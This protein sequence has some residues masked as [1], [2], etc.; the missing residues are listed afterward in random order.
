MRNSSLAVKV[1][2]AVAA[3]SLGAFSITRNPQRDAPPAPGKSV[4]MAQ[5]GLAL[6]IQLGLKDAKS[7]DWD[8]EVR[9][10]PG[11]MALRDAQLQKTDRITGNSWR[12]SSR[13]VGQGP[14]QRTEPVVLYATSEAPPTANVDV[15]TKQGNFSFTLAEL[16]FGAPLTFL[17]G[18]AA[19]ERVPITQQLTSDPTEDDFAACAAPPD[20]SVWCAYVGY[21]RGS[22]LVAEDFNKGKFDSLITRNHGDQVR[23]MKFDGKQWTAPIDVTPAGL[24]V[25]RPT[26]AIDGNGAVWVIWSQ[27]TNGNWDL[28]ARSYDTK[29]NRWSND[30][31]VTSE[32]GADIHSVATTTRSGA[33][34][35]AWQSWGNGDFAIKAQ[36]LGGSGKS[37]PLTRDFPRGN[38]WQPSIA[39]DSKGKVYVAF[40]TYAKGNYDVYVW[41]LDE[42]A[43]NASG[44]IIPVATSS[45][46]EARPTMAV[47]GQDRVWIAYE[48]A[49]PNWG[50][51]YGTRWE[52]KTGAPFYLNRNVAVRCLEGGKLLQTKA[53][54]KSELIDTTYPPSERQR[55]SYP[56]ISTDGAGALWLLFR[57]HALKTGATERW[58]T[59][60]TYYSGDAW[61]GPILLPS[62]EN[63]LDNRPALVPMKGN[64]LLAV[65]SSDGRT[66]GT[67]TAVK[68]NLY[69]ALFSTE[70]SPKNP[71][72]VSVRPEGDGGTA[73]A[74][75]ADET[76][77]VNRIRA[78]RVSV[79][80]KTY[81]PLRG[82]FHR[83]TE[84]S[85]HRDQ[86]GPFEEIW[87]YGLDVARMDWIGPGDH[88]NGVGR[89][90]TWWLTQKQVDIYHHAPVFMPMFTYE[91]SVVFP[92]GHR[93]VMFARRGIRPLPR[94][95]TPQQQE[96]LYGSP[97]AG[98]PDIKNLYAYLKHF[99]GI[100][101][102]HTSATNMG[103]DWRDNDPA[104]EPVVEIY[105]GHRQNYEEPKAPKAAK[106]AE[107]SI[108]GF[109]PE[110]YVWNAFLKGYKLG[111][112]VSSDHV[113][114]HIS[115]GIVY[116][117]KPTR[118]AIVDAFKK[119][120]SYGA[121]DNIILDVRCG[122][123]M[124][125]DEFTSR[126]APK[127]DIQAIGTAPVA[128]IDIVRQIDR[129]T[130]AYVYAVEPKKPNVKI[131]WTDSKA[132]EGALNMY[133][134]RLMQEDGKMAWA[135]PMWIK[136]EP[137]SR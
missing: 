101:S 69:G 89:E 16:K 38:E 54:I 91:R 122:D 57:R 128:R 84:I 53:E 68:N 5:D 77:D 94:M 35:V 44:E 2:V 110:G 32:P 103:T 99:N 123:K 8:G 62:S 49:E 64:G 65:Y 25:W 133:Y 74:V 129:S 106:D 117:E 78:Y 125:G 114:T 85:S 50:K 33:V 63:L 9:I 46:F 15:A 61:S 98:S 67:N 75:H 24:D 80:G 120:H 59:Y 73:E 42:N 10:S 37:T 96:V 6:Q 41:A 48:D 124:M 28:H 90:Y 118:D 116:A 115:Y 20:G 3:V 13:T 107:D 26:V 47:D 83:H 30:Q 88:D 1:M 100:C 81:Q 86:D 121:N 71:V 18:A 56:R 66:G 136:Y 60:A 104:V 70:G 31:R 17:G 21:L 119:R 76:E 93:N 7:T 52:G 27:T 108:G 105:Q 55:L 19:V 135:S 72:L 43:S 22:P 58:V 109:Q 137:A 131:S 111:F 40:D 23:L 36:R 113:S 97:Q 45:R 12:L 79:G 134:V 39:A 51:D 132:K 92:S 130:P 127:L 14:N 34:W 87:R 82:E 102:S 126:A 29:A 4:P 112:Q 95:G 11:Q